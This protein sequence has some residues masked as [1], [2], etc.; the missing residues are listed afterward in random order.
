MN[1]LISAEMLADLIIN[2]INIVI[3]FLVT[4]KLLYKPVKKFLDTRKEKIAAQFEEV[5]LREKEAADAKEEYC[6][7]IGN[8]QVLFERTVNEAKAEARKSAEKIVSEANQQAKKIVDDAKLSAAEEH[9]KMIEN[10]RSDIAEVALQI[11]NKIIQREVTDADNR[12]II[13]SFFAN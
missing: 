12:R 4:K 9:Q 2:I 1:G 11:S 3:L 6:E 5:K 10:A 8:A 13:D 7:L